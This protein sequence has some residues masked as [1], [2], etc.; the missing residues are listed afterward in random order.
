M[1]VG[2]MLE[3][4][5]VGCVTETAIDHSTSFLSPRFYVVVIAKNAME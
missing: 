5:T 4:V 1:D 2:G 3:T